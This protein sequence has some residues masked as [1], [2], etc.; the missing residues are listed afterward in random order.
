[1][2]C[3]TSTVLYP[4]PPDTL[5]YPPPRVL[6]S[7]LTLSTP[8]TEILDS[9]LGEIIFGQ[10]ADVRQLIFFTETSV[11]PCQYVSG[12]L[13]CTNYRLSFNPAPDAVEKVTN[14]LRQGLEGRGKRRKGVTCVVRFMGK[15]FPN[16]VYF[17]VII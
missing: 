7:G 3:T 8:L 16:V 5:S 13:V 4:W 11:Q 15:S 1:M 12:S 2:N 14:H 17:K 9:P 6:V 10:G